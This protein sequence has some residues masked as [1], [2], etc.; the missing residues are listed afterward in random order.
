MYLL[1]NCVMNV[2]F[3][4]SYKLYNIHSKIHTDSTT[5]QPVDLLWGVTKL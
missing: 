2:Q 5:L 4:E 1:L 3:Y